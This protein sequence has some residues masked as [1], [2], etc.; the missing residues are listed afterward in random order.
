MLVCQASQ[1]GG[2]SGLPPAPTNKAATNIGRSSLTSTLRSDPFA[3]RGV[4]HPKLQAAL[5]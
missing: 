4:L 2:G 3:M 1:G 5:V